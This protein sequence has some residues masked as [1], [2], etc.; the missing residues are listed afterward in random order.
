MFRSTKKRSLES[1]LEPGEQILYDSHP[2]NK[3]RNW[4]FLWMAVGLLF[5]FLLVVAILPRGFG[6]RIPSLNLLGEVAERSEVGLG[7]HED[8]LI[9]RFSGHR[10][11]LS[12]AT[13][14]PPLSRTST[15]PQRRPGERGLAQRGRIGRP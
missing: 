13:W 14:F 1:V 7:D 3:P 4:T 6:C 5:C 10:F 11:E 12:V 15:S 8:P 2:G 9:L